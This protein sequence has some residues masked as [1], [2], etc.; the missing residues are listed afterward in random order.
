[1]I[2]RQTFVSI[3]KIIEVIKVDMIKLKWPDI[4]YNGH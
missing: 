2:M 4:T 1:M 3:I